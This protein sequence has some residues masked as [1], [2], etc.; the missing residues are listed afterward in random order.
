MVAARLAPVR[1]VGGVGGHPGGCAA[2]VVVVDI[3]LRT[4]EEVALSHP[5][6]ELRVKLEAAVGVFGGSLAALRPLVR[7]V[8]HAIVVLHRVLPAE[9]AEDAEAVSAEEELRTDHEVHPAPLEHVCHR[10]GDDRPLQERV[11]RVRAEGH[12]CRGAKHH[13]EVRRV[14]GTAHDVV[15]QVALCHTLT[16]QGACLLARKSLTGTV[17]RQ[18]GVRLCKRR[19]QAAQAETDTQ[20]S[21]VHKLVIVCVFEGQK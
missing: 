15:V 16:P 7:H 14:A 2:D 18:G 12:Q 17:G 19:Q 6:E 20:Q 21:L 5:E 9:G 1:Y 4:D 13:P 10:Q 3:E 8:A 11:G